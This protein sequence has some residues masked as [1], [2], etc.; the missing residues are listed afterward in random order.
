MFALP[1]CLLFTGCLVQERAT[2]AFEIGFD[3]ATQYNHRGMVQNEEGVLQTN[4]VI[5]LP[6]KGDGLLRL[7][8]FAN[9]DLSNDTGDAWFPEGHAGEFSEVDLGAS[10]SRDFEG[11]AIA[12]GIV[13]YVLPNGDDFP[14][15]G[16]RGETKELFASVGRE[17]FGFFPAIIVHYDFDEVDDYYVEAEVSRSF[18]LADKL[19]AKLTAG[20]GYSGE[21]ASLWTY[22]I[23]ESGLSDLRGS[24]SVLYAYDDRTVFDVTVGAST[25][26]DD[27]IEEWFDIIEVEQDNVWVSAGV[28]FTF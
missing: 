27:G 10:Y 12:A 26:L 21:D 22:G 18:E 8:G 7:T 14:L 9:M 4:A 23:D 19:S 1:V 16:E 20:V 6:L 25:I 5:G 15:A 17:V 28:T 2:P 11:F 24:G 3:A 13:S